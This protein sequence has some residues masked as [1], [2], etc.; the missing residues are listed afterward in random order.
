[1]NVATLIPTAGSCLSLACEDAKHCEELNL[2]EHLIASGDYG[3]T[4]ELEVMHRFTPGLYS[5]TIFMPK[6]TLLTS[7]IHRT[8]HQFLI[9]KGVLEIWTPAEGWLTYVAPHLGETLPGTRRG[10][11]IHEDTVF[12]TFH[13][14]N[15]TTVEEVEA[16]LVEP[17]NSLEATS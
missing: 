3:P 1:M 4:V 2:L 9:S 13:P 12:T 6:G 8:H 15:L 14:T 5:R 11:R 10:L 7:K 16:Y 17:F